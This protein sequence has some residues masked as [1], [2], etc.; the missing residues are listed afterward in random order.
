MGPFENVVV[1]CAERWVCGGEN[2]DEEGEDYVYDQ[3]NRDISSPQKIPF[4]NCKTYCSSNC[5]CDKPENPCY[6]STR[7][8]TSNVENFGTISSD[9]QRHPGRDRTSDGK[10]EINDI[11]LSHEQSSR[12]VRSCSS[13]QV[14]ELQIVQSPTVSK[15]GDNGRQI[16]DENNAEKTPVHREKV[17]AQP[18]VA[19]CPFLRR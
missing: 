11:F 8:D 13:G 14:R 16:S 5:E 17:I 1:L 10:Q 15:D 12:D 3:N 9:K 4:R 7:M 2:E 6:A 18:H 19:M